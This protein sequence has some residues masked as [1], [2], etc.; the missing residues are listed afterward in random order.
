MSALPNPESH[1]AA[2]GFRVAAGFARAGKPLP[3]VG[4]EITIKIATADANG[5][6]TVF[7]DVTPPL[8]GPP[9]HVHHVQDEWWYILEGN[10]LFEVDG[11]QIHA[12]PGDVVFA[13]HGSRHAFMNTGQT[14]ARSL[15]TV[16]PGGLDLFFEELSAEAP[17]AAAAAA[18]DP[19]LIAY[20]F[21]RHGME[22][23]GPPLN[24]R[25]EERAA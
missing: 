11:E 14:L 23:L 8:G 16:V 19:E 9:L 10:Y 3:V 18:A 2:S 6:C 13:P 5:A 12:R 20:I 15:I 17:T 25:Y 7:E 1:P 4:D 24:V 21:R 22:L